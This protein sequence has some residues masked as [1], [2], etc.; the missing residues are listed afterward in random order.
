MIANMRYGR[1][2]FGLL[3][4]V[5]AAVAGSVGVLWAYGA[6]AGAEW[7]YCN[8]GSCTEGEVMAVFLIL[9]A[10]IAGVCGFLLLRGARFR[11]D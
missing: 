5:F 4:V 9:P 1:K 10:V 8:G 3:L 11:G 6:S 7:D 2:L